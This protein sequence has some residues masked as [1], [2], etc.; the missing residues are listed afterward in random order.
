MSKEKFKTSKERRDAVNAWREKNKKYIKAAAE[1][2][3]TLTAY[4]KKHGIGKVRERKAVAPK[5]VRVKKE[6]A[7]SGPKLAHKG[8][9]RSAA[10]IVHREPAQPKPAAPVASAWSNS[11]EGRIA[12]FMETEGVSRATAVQMMKREERK[13]LAKSAITALPAAAPA[14]ETKKVHDPLAQ[15]T[16]VLA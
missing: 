8:K 10:P 15:A 12:Y 2:G 6:K 1:E 9:S 16:P 7:A 14:T 13:S 11:Q 4:R 5:A 3:I